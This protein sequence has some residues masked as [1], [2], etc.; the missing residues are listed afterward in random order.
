MSIAP[1]ANPTVPFDPASAALTIAQAIPVKDPTVKN[2]LG[3]FTP[4]GEPISTAVLSIGRFFLG[5][6]AQRK[7]EKEARLA[8]S[9][10]R[11]MGITGIV[12]Q[13]IADY[14]DPSDPATYSLLQKAE[15]D[16]AITD[17]KDTQ[18][19]DRQS[20]IAR[21]AAPIYARQLAQGRAVLPQD[22]SEFSWPRGESSQAI[23]GTINSGIIL[24]AMNNVARA[25][26]GGKEVNDLIKEQTG[27]EGFD[28]GN[29]ARDF[30][31][32]SNFLGLPRYSTAGSVSPTVG[33]QISNAIDSA[34]GN[35]R[36][37]TFDPFALRETVQN[38]R[39]IPQ[40]QIIQTGGAV[41]IVPLVV[42]GVGAILIFA[43]AKRGSYGLA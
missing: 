30:E 21:E 1:T 31:F 19:G 16:L 27:R 35:D 37:S 22:F 34:L 11:D 23:G 39:I 26:Y 20:A 38:D 3:S 15:A 42:L 9:T 6:S 10:Q 14:F 29:A 24:E 41:N 5:Q 43:L 7:A 33:Q 18:R 28:I 17:I 4:T 2:A 36:P 13:F 32:A 25:L 40:T 8:A 12:G